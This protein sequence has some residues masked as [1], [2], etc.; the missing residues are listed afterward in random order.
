M[1]ANQIMQEFRAR[2]QQETEGTLIGKGLARLGQLRRLKAGENFIDSN[3]QRWWKYRNNEWPLSAGLWP[4]PL[5]KWAYLSNPLPEV[6]V[7][8][9]PTDAVLEGQVG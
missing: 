6:E 2:T 1:D 9:Q 7:Q 8:P 4:P 3:G 5:N